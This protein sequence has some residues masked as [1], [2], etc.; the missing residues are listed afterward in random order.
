MATLTSTCVFLRFCV[1]KNV[2]CCFL[3]KQRF[4]IANANS[5]VF[6]VV[7]VLLIHVMDIVW[8]LFLILHCS[9]EWKNIAANS[10][11]WSTFIV[12]RNKKNSQVITYL[13]CSLLLYNFSFDYDQHVGIPPWLLLISVNSDSIQPI[14]I[15][16]NNRIVYCEYCCKLKMDFD[17][18]NEWSFQV[19]SSL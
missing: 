2:V 9:N 12:R 8:S 10:S 4:E 1:I 16:G 15:M 18:F 7:F 3:S 11:T 13:N 19:I 14:I 6:S 5:F 17:I